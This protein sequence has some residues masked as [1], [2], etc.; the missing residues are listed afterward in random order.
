MQMNKNLL[1]EVKQWYHLIKTVYYTIFLVMNILL[2]YLN[3]DM[4]YLYCDTKI[5]FKYKYYNYLQIQL[6]IQI[7]TN[8]NL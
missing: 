2:E 7:F 5:I 4:I 3:I 1:G 8:I 6:Q